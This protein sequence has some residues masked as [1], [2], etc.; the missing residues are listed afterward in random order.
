LLG[1]A[2]NMMRPHDSLR[3][4]RPRPGLAPRPLHTM[5]CMSLALAAPACGLD[6]EDGGD[7]SLGEVTSAATVSSFITSSC[8]TAVVIGLS[9]QIADE[10]GCMA[11]NS[12]VRF[13]AGNGITITSNAVLP[14][15][16]SIAR[17]DLL[18]VGN[19][20]I[21]SAFRTIA[22]QYLL[23][24]WFNRG[25]C[26]ITAAAP[27]GRSNHE[28]GRAVDLANWSSRVTAMGNR[29]WSHSVP[30]DPVHF[31][32]LAS[33]DIRGR[34]TLAFQ[35]LWNRNHPNDRIAADGIYGPQ[36]EARL[37]QSPAT[38]F[39]TGPSCGARIRAAAELVAV[40][41]PD[42]VAPGGRARYRITIDNTTGAEWP[43][44]TRLVV[45]GGAPSELYD[46]STWVSSSEVGTIGAAIPAG[47]QGA[48]EID[49]V[50]PTDITEPTA[51]S[52]EL[53]L[54]DGATQ[55]G[56][57]GLAF[58]VTPDGDEHMSGDSDDQHDIIEEPGQDPGATPDGATSGG[59]STGGGAGWLALAPAL[60]ALLR[61]RRR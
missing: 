1:L 13:A 12:L 4:A 30:G 33:P 41:G 51:L 37:R 23:L 22:A 29:G 47:A 11:P 35:R 10:I 2:G 60:L 50:A 59:C 58:T 31:D 42:R 6:G 9:A 28:S 3:L 5:L 16:S 56:T 26:G 19:V 21:N 8:T 43:A 61:R 54:L 18:A 55:V 39:A 7:P 52:S 57:V 15:L 46:A 44:S 32:H 53:E 36:T 14:Y 20:Q 38:G 24:Q 48:I 40:D 49:V 45:A 34:D 25:R 27:V 17:R